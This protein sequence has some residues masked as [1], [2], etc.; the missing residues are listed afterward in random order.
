MGDPVEIDAEHT[1]T[2][3]RVVLDEVREQ[4]PVAHTD[5][6]VMLLR[7]ADVVAAAT[8]PATFSSTVSTRRVIPNGLDGSEHAVYR[9]IVDSYLGPA[10]VADQEG[11]CRATATAIVRGLP[12]GEMVRTITDIG[13]PYAVRT[14]SAW[15]GWPTEL[16]ADLVAWM[17]RNHAA[18]RSGE[19]TR[20]TMVAREFDDMIHSLLAERRTGPA[21][22]V[23]GALMREQV[24]GRTLT[25]AEVVSILRNFTAGDLGSLATSA[26]VIV[27]YLACHSEIQGW[28]RKQLSTASPTEIEDALNEILRIDDPFVSN[29]RRLTRQVQ[30][31]GTTLDADTQVLLNWT[32][33]NRDPR[34]FDDPDEYDPAGH[35]EANLVFGIGPH[36]CPARGLTLMELRVLT[37]VLLQE[38]TW[39]ELDAHEPAVREIPPVGGWARVPVVLH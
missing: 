24:D 32:A 25:D 37:E 34:V 6:N 11:Q 16:E 17:A 31:G 22:D 7:H 26:G 10:Q 30:V 4:C 12:R 19:R 39:I 9:A 27:H 15:L 20:T 18:T 35:A 3:Q 13:V 23:T 33:A 29:R 21:T 28:L 36:V 5:G 1:W 2:D 38:T 14:M 8:D